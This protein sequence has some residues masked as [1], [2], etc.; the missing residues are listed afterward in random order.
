MT[1]LKA[2]AKAKGIRHEV[3][4]LSIT[5]WM[6]TP[7]FFHEHMNE[8]ARSSI[9]AEELAEFIPVKAVQKFDG[10][11]PDRLLNLANGHDY[12]DLL[13][14]KQAAEQATAANSF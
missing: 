3:D 9:S 1:T 10:F 4:K 14:A 8:I 2:F 13:E 12:F 7:Q 11:I 5:Y 6:E